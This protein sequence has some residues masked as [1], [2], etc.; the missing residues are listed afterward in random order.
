MSYKQPAQD[1]LY[2]PDPYRSS[3]HD[4]VIIGLDLTTFSM[5]PVEVSKTM[6]PGTQVKIP[7]TISNHGLT[8]DTYDI[9]RLPDVLSISIGFPTVVGPLEPGESATFD[10]TIT[11]SGD[12]PFG[13]TKTY[14]LE[15]TSR[16]YSSSLTSTINVLIDYLKIYLPLIFK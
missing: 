10:A 13:T 4:P 8:S 2:A 11:V 14:V 3:D 5:T 1:A 12:E 15:A 9:T 16:L 7:I 6:L